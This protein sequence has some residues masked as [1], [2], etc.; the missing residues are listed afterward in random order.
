MTCK[1][2]S[3]SSLK[4]SIQFCILLFRYSVVSDSLQ[5]DG[6]Q[7][8]RLPCPSLS[9]RVCSN[10]CPLSQWYH[11]TISSSIAPFFSCLQSF[12]ASG[13]FPKSRLFVSGRQSIGA[14]ASASVLPMLISFRIDWFEL[15]AVQGTLKSLLQHHS[16][17][18]SVL[19]RSY[20]YIIPQYSNTLQKMKLNWLLKVWKVIHPYSHLVKREMQI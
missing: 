7:H 13:S 6:L 16:L 11:P 9:P 19:Q 8:T 5:P 15:F 18:A 1:L 20:Y 4:L 17:K 12:L 14:S 3:V 10:S 2:L